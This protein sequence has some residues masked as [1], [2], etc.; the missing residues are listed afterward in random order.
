L[1]AWRFNL[2]EV[3]SELADFFSP[4]VR[5][6]DDAE[7]IAEGISHRCHFDS[8]AHVLHWLVDFRSQIR[9]PNQLGSGV[10]NSPINLYASSTRLA[11]RDQSQLEPADRKTDIE[12]LVKVRLASQYVAIPLFPSSEIRR[13]I[14]SP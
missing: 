13:W 9:Q 3:H 10:S 6:L 14:G 1:A 2:L 4:E 7:Q 5:V 8:A 11:V 12:R